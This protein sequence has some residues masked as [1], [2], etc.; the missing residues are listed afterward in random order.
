MVNSNLHQNPS[1]TCHGLRLKDFP[2][3]G[4]HAKK[5]GGVSCRSGGSKKVGLDFGLIADLGDK[6]HFIPVASNPLQ[7]MLIADQ[8][9]N[10][11]QI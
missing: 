7:S 6:N 1:T 3:E 9:V 11:N 4:V 5:A 2:S 10:S 8:F